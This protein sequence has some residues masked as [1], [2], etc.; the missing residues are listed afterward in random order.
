MIYEPV[1]PTKMGDARGLGAALFRD[2]G[3]LDGRGP[4]DVARDVVGGAD[5]HG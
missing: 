2:D 4:G 3:V 1:R 5:A